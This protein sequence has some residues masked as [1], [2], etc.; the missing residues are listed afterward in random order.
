M[1]RWSLCGYRF[2]TYERGHSWAYALERRWATLALDHVCYAQTL[3]VAVVTTAV[4][5]QTKSKLD[6]LPRDWAV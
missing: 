6:Y 3:P 1:R 5:D 4:L 2:Y